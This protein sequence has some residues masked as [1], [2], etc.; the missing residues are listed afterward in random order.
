MKLKK[1]ILLG[2]V[3][4]ICAAFFLPWV[5]V[6]SKAVGG[7]S[8]FLTGTEQSSIATISGF[9]VP[10][11]ANGEESRLMISIIKIFQPSV[12][13]AD[14]KSYLIWGVPLLSVLLFGISN[15]FNKK[16]WV[17]LSIALIGIAIFAVGVF[18]I[19]TTDM[20]KV[21]IQVN[22]ALGLWLTLCGYLT[23]G[24]TELCAF[25]KGCPCR[26]K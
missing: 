23:L 12:T 11:L 14:K 7:V 1:V 25:A 9:Q 20:D 13:D 5:S 26:K 10:I 17:H 15:A 6:D 2:T 8:K 18:K 19:T 22:M 3:I 16:R 21:I 4:I 24:L